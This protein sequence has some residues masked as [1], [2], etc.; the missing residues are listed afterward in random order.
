MNLVCFSN[1]TGGGLLCDLLNGINESSF[2]LYRVCSYAHGLFK[3][4]DSMSVLRQFD[5][6]KWLLQLERM[7]TL[8][9]AGSVNKNM[10]FGTHCHPSCIPHKYISMFDK[11]L[12]IT[13][14]ST[15]SKLLR[16]IRMYNGLYKIRGGVWDGPAPEYIAQSDHYYLSEKIDEIKEMCRWTQCGFES[17]QYGDN[18]EFEDIVNGNYVR[19]NKLSVDL[20]ETWKKHN[21]WLYEPVNPA[22]SNIFYNEM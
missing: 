11:V 19:E 12:A 5:E 9:A 10:W 13:T 6:G 16:F 3:I 17:Y 18:V 22:L 20:L 15:T 7:D 21:H 4:G 14:E 1:Q 2:N 8:I